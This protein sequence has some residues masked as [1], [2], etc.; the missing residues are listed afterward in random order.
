MNFNV[1]KYHRFSKNLLFMIFPVL[2]NT[3]FNSSNGSAQSGSERDVSYLIDNAFL[4]SRIQRTMTLLATSNERRRYPVKILVYGQSIMGG[5][6]RSNLENTIRE[7]FP[8][9]VITYENRAIAG[10]SAGQLVRS[11]ELDMYPFYPD[12]IIFRDGGASRIEFERM[13][14]DIRRYTTSDIMILTY[15]LTK[16]AGKPGSEGYAARTKRG[17]NDSD[18]IRYVAQK[19]NCELVDVRKEWEAYLIEHALDSEELLSDNVHMNEKGKPVFVDII[20]RHF[21]LHSNIPNNWMDMVRTYEV[22]RLADDGKSD[23]ITFTGEPW[24]FIGAAAIG[25]NPSSALKLEFDGNRVDLIAGYIKD[26]KMGTAEILIDGKPPSENPRLYT[27]TIPSKAHGA[28]WQPAIRRITYK[29]AP[30]IEDWVLKITE[31]S[32]NAKKITF[33]V[34]GSKT[35]YDGFGEFSAEKYPFHRFGDILPYDGPE[36]YPDKFISNSGRVVIDHR[37]FKITWA[38]EYSGEKCPVGFETR[39]SVKPLFVDTY[40][41]PVIENSSYI[42]LITLAKGLSNGKHTLEIIPNGDGIIPI[43]RIIVHRPPLR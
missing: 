3:A 12:L 41:A 18:I 14:A 39:W 42:N 16:F 37:D 6:K 43:E 17:D 40:I 29:N 32:D 35:G 24:R 28:N 2:V 36:P 19:Y 30:L 10:F 7:R 23:E 20:M 26:R 25:E 4:G 8:Y 38:Q 22:N 11:S 31:I 5:L 13:I 21:K 27:H 9:A 34:H 1:K 15:H 33:E